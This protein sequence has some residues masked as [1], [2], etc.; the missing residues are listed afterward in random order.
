MAWKVG[1]DV[2]FG[3]PDIRCNLLMEDGKTASNALNAYLHVVRL[4]G[5]NTPTKRE[6]ISAVR[7]SCRFET[8]R[9]VV[10][11][12]AVSSFHNKTNLS[13]ETPKTAK[14]SSAVVTQTYE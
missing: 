10:P 8:T 2:L 11:F 3:A 14:D 6:S 9:L 13:G 4:A 7:T 5:Q 12:L 1:V